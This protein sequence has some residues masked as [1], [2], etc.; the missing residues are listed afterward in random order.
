MLDQPYSDHISTQEA[1]CRFSAA[2]GFAYDHTGP[3]SRSADKRRFSP[4]QLQ[5]NLGDTDATVK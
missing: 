2:A 3:F 5:R 1:S 4:A